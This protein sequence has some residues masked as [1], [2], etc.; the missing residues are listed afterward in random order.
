MCCHG[1]HLG[2]RVL[3]LGLR[4]WELEKDKPG[5]G[6]LLETGQQ[7]AGPWGGCAPGP[8]PDGSVTAV[9]AAGTLRRTGDSHPQLYPGPPE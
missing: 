2:Q 5:S 3:V 4:K 7:G 1:C 9:A 8:A 6:S